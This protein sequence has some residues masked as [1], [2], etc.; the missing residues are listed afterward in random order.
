MANRLINEK[1]PYLLQHAHNPVDWYPWGEEAFAQARQSNKPVFLSVGYATC[2]WCHVMER[3]SFENQA[4]ADALNQSFVNIKVDREER[5]DIDAVYMAACHMVTGSGGWPLTIV[6]TPEKKPFFAGTYI[7]RETGFG[8][9]GLIDLAQ[10]ISDLWNSEP[11]RALTSAEALISHLRTAFEFEASSDIQA[12]EKVLQR[13][14]DQISGRFDSTWGGFDGAPKFPMPHRLLFLGRMARRSNSTGVIGMIEKT[15]TAMRLGGIWDHVGF[16]FHR[17]STDAQWRLPHFEKMLYD[18]ALVALAYL[19][20]YE[21]TGNPLFSQTAEEIFVYVLRDMTDAQGGFY[22]AEDADSEGEEGKCY[23][24]TKSEF[25]SLVNDHTEGIPWSDLFNLADDGN[26]LDEATQKKAGTNILHLNRPLDGWARELNIPE[27]KL[28]E[29]WEQL[30]K[31]LFGVRKKRVPPLKDDKILTDWNGLMITALAKGYR[32]LGEQ[33]Y[34]DAAGAAADFVLSR[35]RTDGGDLLHRFRDGAAAIPGTANDYAF[36]T[37][38]LIEL[39]RA[40]SEIQW[41]QHAAALQQLM[42]AQFWDTLNKGF[43]LTA[44]EQRDLPVRPKELYDGALPSANAVAMSNLLHLGQLLNDERWT[45]QAEDL[46]Q[47]FAGSVQR[48]PMAYTHML[49]GWD[50]AG[51]NLREDDHHH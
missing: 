35:L 42:N 23:L 11:E 21:L 22:A 7:P 40:S 3:E 38:G 4:A 5:P 41:I 48:Q 45:R 27:S 19:Q 28:A 8:R 32:T 26:F 25:E 33:R 36:L 31:R 34:L 6:M 14:V 2:H 44:E 51:V 50:R 29:D 9:L 47:A 17:Y 12:T 1:S 39:Y 46:R 15:L 37:M 13:A 16:G 18:Q 49:S 30:R 43:F 10:R 24:W 20:G